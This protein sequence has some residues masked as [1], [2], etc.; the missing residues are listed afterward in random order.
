MHRLSNCIDKNTVRMNLNTLL[1]LIDN[2]Y[3]MQVGY[4]LVIDSDRIAHS[5]EGSLVQRH[6]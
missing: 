6:N 3:K 4:W 5:N 2:L 1:C